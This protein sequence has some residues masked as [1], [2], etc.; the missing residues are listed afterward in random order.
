M[1]SMIS[2]E[3]R[4]IFIHIPRTAGTSFEKWILGKD[5]WQINPAEKHLTAAQAKEVYSK[6][7]K[8]YWK[9]T[10]LRKPE[11]RF[12]SML[13]YKD[14]F[15]VTVNDNGE[16]DISGYLRKFST[17]QEVVIEHDHRFTNLASSFD[18]GIRNGYPPSQGA[19]YGNII[20]NEIDAVFNYESLDKIVTYLSTRTGLDPSGFPHSEKRIISQSQY[21][22]TNETRHI[23]QELH[24]LDLYPPIRLYE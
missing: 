17:E 3:H 18:C 20:G 14:H 22:V 10:I 7:W 11:D 19:L 9:F 4:L 21:V 1:K 23:I 15:G 12:I 2:H 16:L 8:N 5:Q 6:H 24:S 13:K